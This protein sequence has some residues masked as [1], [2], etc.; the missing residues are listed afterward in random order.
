MTRR[1][2]LRRDTAANWISVDPILAAGEAGVDLDTLK[3]KIGNGTNR[4]SELDY[5]AGES[6]VDLSGYATEEYVDQAIASVTL[7]SITELDHLELTSRTVSSG[8]IITFEKLENT[9]SVDEIDTDLTI[10]RPSDV[11]AGL[12]NTALE[13][14]W[15]PASSPAGTV[16]NWDGWGNLDTVKTRTYSS[17]R[18][19]LKHRIGDNVVG[20]ELVMH[21]LTNN[22]Y[23]K[24]KVT[25]WAQ[26]PAHTGAFSYTRELIDT[27]YK[28]GVEFPDG[29]SLVTRPKDYLDLPQVFSGDT[30]E[31]ILGLGDRGKHIYA[32]TE[33]AIRI[34]S[35]E[36]VNFPI[37]STIYIVTGAITGQNGVRITSTDSTTL[38]SQG[39]TGLTVLQL[40]PY[41]SVI[42]VKIEQYKWNVSVNT[43]NITFEET[44]ISAPDGADIIIDGKVEGAT[45]ARLEI[46]SENSVAKLESFTSSQENFYSGDG[47][48]T[49]ANWTVSQFG[50]GQLV[51]TGAEQLYAFLDSTTNEWDNGSNKQF[52]WNEGELLSWQGYSYGG[53]TLT[54]DLGSELL[55]P[56]DPTEV[57]TL[58]LE[59][60]NVSRV[61]VDSGDFSELQISGR[62]INVEIN[63]TSDVNIEAGDDLRLT[64]RDIVSIRNKATDEPVTIV[65]NYD[66]AAHTWQF[67]ANGELRL[68]S[69]GI[70]R[71]TVV[72]ENPTIEL[73]PAG[74]EA[75]SQKLLIKGGGPT[76]SNIENGITVEVY[77]TLTYNQG[78]IVYM[79]VR[80]SLPQGTTLYWW[81][82]NYSDG[83]NTFFNPDNGEVVLDEFG[84]G[85][86]NFVVN[87]D[88]VT[89]RVYVADTLYNAYI[90]NLGAVS[91]DMN[92]GAV[93]NS[94]HLHLTTGDLTA[95]SIFLGTDD[96][97][98]RTKP[99]GAI[100]L[101][102]YDYDSEY[103]YRLNFKNNILSISSENSPNNEDL[104]LRAEDDLYL[105]ARGDDLHIRAA[106]IL[107][108]GVGFDF[109]DGG[110]TSTWRFSPQLTGEG[111]VP[112]RIEFPD[113]TQQTTA[114]AGGR[115]VSAP[116]FSIGATGDRAG[117]LSFTSGYIYYCTADYTGTPTTVTWTNVLDV[118][119]AGEIPHHVQADITDPS[120]LNGNL[121]ITNVIVNGAPA[122]TETVTSFELVSGNTYRFFLANTS[123]PWNI[124]QTTT[125]QVVPNIWRRVSW[126]SDTW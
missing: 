62:G 15:N 109:E 6:A 49:T 125:L 86:F 71:E 97:N 9:N 52:S 51:F 3:I 77:N 76:Y 84:S 96:H 53:G 58:R 100:E 64:G 78:D 19:T 23:Y 93:D 111:V 55:P 43:G 5:L 28:V 7:E 101:T 16:W 46:S 34:P 27:S 67:E 90:N 91:V 107:R 56:T 50:R 75:A 22:K 36:S 72:T 59:W 18:Q 112:A 85:Y 30:N 94:L 38:E 70:I 33:S 45:T 118:G 104:Y 13:S 121:T 37:G 115:V 81:V 116:S 54:I 1:I 63:S 99:D 48:W 25:S 42:L 87:D 32:F 83:T 2:Q 11:G 102:S 47:L 119:E 40:S 10:T 20:A 68:P 80:T 57:T 95:T 61:S 60:D 74:A 65:T 73:E 31:Y 113:G 105:E 122:S 8:D 82:D 21:D 12:I 108:I 89:F 66:G 14:S 26:G 4:W 39:K 88:T 92:A 41:S 117:D 35:V 69:N 110:A 103:A 124:L 24:I 98:V 17:F 120:Q 44:T 123:E 106:D 126:S 79:G 29:T 114:W